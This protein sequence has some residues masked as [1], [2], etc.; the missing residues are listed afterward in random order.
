MLTLPQTRA[1]ARESFKA[2]LTA[3]NNDDSVR[4]PRTFGQAAQLTRSASHAFQADESLLLSHVSLFSP[5]PA[6]RIPQQGISYLPC[7][8]AHCKAEAY[9]GIYVGTC[10]LKIR[11]LRHRTIAA[12]GG[13]F[14]KYSING[15]WQACVAHGCRRTAEF[16]VS[17]AAHDRVPAPMPTMAGAAAEAPELQPSMASV[18]GGPDMPAASAG[19]SDAP[20][21]SPGTRPADVK[22]VVSSCMLHS[23]ANGS[24]SV[25]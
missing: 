2:L 21:A 18:V 6:Q 8:S 13:I 11:V 3:A 20:A 19:V 25:V 14:H 16:L 9:L 12:H 23:L 4:P 15:D 1:S 7:C 17:R 5:L 10:S 24:L 22:L